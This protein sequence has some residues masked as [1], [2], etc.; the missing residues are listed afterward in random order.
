MIDIYY[1]DDPYFPDEIYD[2]SISEFADYCESEWLDLHCESFETTKEADAFINGL[3][4]GCDETCPSELL[5][6]RTDREDDIPYIE[7]YLSV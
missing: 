7:A 2:M 3:T 4:A 1:I 5:L 6:L